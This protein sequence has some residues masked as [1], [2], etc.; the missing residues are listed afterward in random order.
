MRLDNLT[1]PWDPERTS[2]H[3]HIAG[4]GGHGIMS[5]PDE[6]PDDGSIRWIAGGLDGA[7]G[8]HFSVSD[9]NSRAAMIHRA[10]A[11]V[12]DDPS[13]DKL[14]LL[15]QQLIAGSA[16]ECVDPLL[17]R[18]SAGDLDLAQL[19][20]LALYLVT[21]APDRDAVKLAMAILGLFEGDDHADLF[22]TL[23]THEELTLYAAVALAS[24][25]TG[26]RRLFELAR[27]VHGWGRIQT[28][29]RLAGTC[30]PEI[31]AWLLREGYK[32]DVMYEYL[33]YTCATS[34]GLREAL[35]APEIDAALLAGATDIIAALIAGGPAQDIGDYADGAAV[36]AR[37]LDHLGDHD[38]DVEQLITCAAIRDHFDGDLSERAARIVAAPRWR[39]L[40]Q[41]GL[42]ADD[43]LTF[44]RASH[45]AELLDID[46]WPHHFERLAR[47]GDGWYHAM[48]T[49]DRARINR[50]VEL[51]LERLDL[52]AV[53]T[54][55]DVA[56]GMGAEFAEHRNLGFVVQGLRSFAGAGLPLIEA[57]LRSPVIANR[58]MA[59]NALEAWGAR[60]WPPEVR[61]ALERALAAEP[62][63]GVRDR[64]T[65]LMA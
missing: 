11:V 36:V 26:E 24:G 18:L 64:L 34:G 13:A 25:P 59:L 30:D 41:A 38:S 16:L 37:Y 46:T 47:G 60:R 58:N 44:H 51:A 5:L 29:E 28:V 19:E 6:P 52:A 35:E 45:A 9:E 7:V 50:V 8:R 57:A 27:E 12:I 1:P 3:D 54:G 49:D 20:E 48:Q 21:R 42:D 17:E 55:A 61:P 22:L 15:Y 39:A 2:I 32:N 4:G 53:A 14:G 40:V 33:A 10:L 65:A 43:H 31:Q 63:D 23:G 62:D 56:L